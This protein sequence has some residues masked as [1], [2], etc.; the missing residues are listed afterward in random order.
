MYEC[1]VCLSDEKTVLLCKTPCGH[2]I[3]ANCI[4]RIKKYECPMCRNSFP[5]ME[6]VQKARGYFNINESSKET[7][8]LAINDT[9]EFPSLG[10]LV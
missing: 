5:K 9:D 10:V 3:C 4:L 6:D 2:I 8:P 1:C 7:G